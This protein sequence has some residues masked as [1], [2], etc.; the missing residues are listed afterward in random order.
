MGV[1]AFSGRARG[2]RR[3]RAVHVGKHG[4][5]KGITLSLDALDANLASMYGWL[6][7]HAGGVV[8]SWLPL[9]HDMGLIGLALYAICS[10][11]P[12]WSTPTDLV[13]MSPEDFLADPGRWMRA[14]S[15]YKATSTTSPPFALTPRLPDPPIVRLIRPLVAAQLCGGKRARAGGRPP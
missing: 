12:P 2:T 8:C 5:P 14:C 13:L 15:D 9:S 7:P 11:N 1:W 4:A 6:E 3:L 10:V